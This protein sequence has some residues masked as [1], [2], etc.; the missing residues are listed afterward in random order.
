VARDGRRVAWL[1]LELRARCVGRQL[2]ERV[3]FE[4]VSVRS[5]A[6]GADGRFGRFGRILRYDS[7]PGEDDEVFPVVVTG[8]LAGGFT[9]SR[10][11]EGT[12]T[13]SLRG[14]FYL[15]GSSGE[16]LYGERAT[17]RTG[18]IRFSAE[19][20]RESRSRLGALRELR[21]PGACLFS[22]LRAGCRPVPRVGAPDRILLSRD[23]RH[24][25]VVSSRPD[26]SGGNWRAWLLGFKRDRRTGTLT[27][28]A[29]EDG[30]LRADPAPGCAT[31]R[32][33][34]EVF[35]AAISPDGRTLYVVSSEP[36]AI[37]TVR[38]DPVTGALRQ[39][40]GSAGCLGPPAED[41]GPLPPFES[42]WS[43]EVSPDGRHIY[44]PWSGLAGATD[45]G[46]MW[47]PRNRASGALGPMTAPGCIGARGAPPC[48]RAPVTGDVQLL[49]LSRDGRHV[50]AS[51][52]GGVLAGF[53]RTTSN[54]ALKPLPEPETCHFARGPRGC[55]RRDNSDA[56]AL[57]V[58]P[59]GRTLYYAFE[60]AIALLAR[61]GDG[62]LDQ[63]AGQWACV[64]SELDSGCRPTRGLDLLNA[65]A[66]SPDGRNV[67]TGDYG[68][69]LM[70]IFDRRRDGRL[71]QLTGG[72]G[73]LVGRYGVPIPLYRPWRCTRTGL[74]DEVTAIAPSPDGRHVYVASGV[75]PDY[76]GLHVFSRRDR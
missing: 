25:Y 34:D 55:R 49:A 28:I 5:L 23:G 11:L 76:G 47:L 57:A 37:A 40:P 71:L 17:C 6:V 4:E 43:P 19:L 12:A 33:L 45:Q 29:G 35:D 32:G 31:L 66:V 61:R 41:C 69:G 8:G 46:L 30:C 52:D 75:W 65:L 42:V 48:R 22:R 39:L 16:G 3:K 73:C 63:L 51:L 36:P 62:G 56:T 18:R 9:S 15:G 1:D 67:Y 38:R 68:D 14:R 20:P 27:P 60:S 24:T 54:G 21:S 50:Y 2:A 13:L 59:D 72:A 64:G 7:G 44:V 53:R 58:S 10:R 26:G 74:A 70:A